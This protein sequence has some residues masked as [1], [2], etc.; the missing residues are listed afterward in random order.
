MRLHACGS[1]RVPEA[2]QPQKKLG[3]GKTV[4]GMAYLEPNSNRMLKTVFFPKK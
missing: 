2:H 1:Q 3:D 4:F